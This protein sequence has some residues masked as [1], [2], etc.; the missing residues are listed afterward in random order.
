ML[1][2]V[3]RSKVR[4]TSPW[5]SPL[6]AGHRLSREAKSDRAALSRNVRGGESIGCAD[7]SIVGMCPVS[8][9]MSVVYMY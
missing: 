9:E 1:Y 4:E 3:D 5:M 2:I 6:I 7:S 8:W